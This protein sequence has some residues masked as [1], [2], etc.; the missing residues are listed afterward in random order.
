M[1]AG[2]RHIAIKLDVEGKDNLLGDSKA[3]LFVIA[4]SE[5][6]PRA[7]DFALFVLGTASNEV[8]VLWEGRV[9]HKVMGQSM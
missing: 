1:L 2:I 6:R 5:S 7:Y 4:Y 8:R 3:I 9:R